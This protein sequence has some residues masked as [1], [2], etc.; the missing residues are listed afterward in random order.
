MNY[1]EKKQ[2]HRPTDPACGCLVPTRVS[3]GFPPI[4]AGTQ[5][6]GVNGVLAKICSILAPRTCALPYLEMRSS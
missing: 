1:Q 5:C 2:T 3:Q 6:C 4:S